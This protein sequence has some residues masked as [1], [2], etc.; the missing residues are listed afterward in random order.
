MPS[1]IVCVFFLDTSRDAIRNGI[2]SKIEQ[3]TTHEYYLG[4]ERAAAALA[5]VTTDRAAIIFALQNHWDISKSEASELLDYEFSFSRPRR[6]F[7]DYLKN[8]L[9]FTNQ[10]ASAFITERNVDLLLR[11]D[12]ELSRLK[13]AKLYKEIIRRSS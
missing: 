13:P 1:A 9:K 3:S 5:D 8:T 4:L 6:Q 7:V 12:P 11:H 10:E 2:E